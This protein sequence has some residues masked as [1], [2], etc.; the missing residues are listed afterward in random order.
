MPQA[1]RRSLVWCLA[2]IVMA[3]SLAACAAQRSPATL[4][5]QSQPQP[6]PDCLAI[7]TQQY[8]ECAYGSQCMMVARCDMDVCIPRQQNCEAHCAGAK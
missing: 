7:C 4:V 1:Q 5:S 3:G 6:G 2:T 8:K